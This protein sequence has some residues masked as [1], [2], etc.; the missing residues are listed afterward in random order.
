MAP[1]YDEIMGVRFFRCLDDFI[2]GRIGFPIGNVVCYGVIEKN[3]ILCDNA[4]MLPERFNGIILH[5]YAV[6]RDN[7][8]RC[9]VEP[10]HEI[11]NGHFAGTSAAYNGDH[12]AAFDFE[13]DTF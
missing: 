1:G 11:G 7:A 5:G 2:H 8:V 10:G 6:N 9:I 3:R 13:T 12:A 4:D